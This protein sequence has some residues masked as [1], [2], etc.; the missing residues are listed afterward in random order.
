M[1]TGSI[2]TIIVALAAL[3]VGTIIS[4]VI[5]RRIMKA[6]ETGAEEKAK[7]ILREAEAEAEVLKKN[8]ILEAKEKF[9]QLK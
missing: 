4:W 7:T 9:L 2:L 8:K 3:A 1:E 6:K 5:L